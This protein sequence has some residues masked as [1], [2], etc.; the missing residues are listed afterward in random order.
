[1]YNAYIIGNGFSIN[2]VNLLI[3]REWIDK[4]AIDLRNLFSQGDVVPCA[5]NTVGFLSPNC[6]PTLWRIGARAYID[7]KESTQIISN[8]ICSYNVYQSIVQQNETVSIH[9]CQTSYF[10]LNKYL[11]NLFVYY[12]SLISDD[13]LKKIINDLPLLNRIK[14][15][16]V[17]ISYNYDI[18][19]ERLLSIKMNVPVNMH[20]AIKYV[21][22]I[23]IIKPHGSIDFKLNI[24]N[25]STHDLYYHQ[26]HNI[27]LSSNLKE[28]IL[29]KDTPALIIP[30]LGHIKGES[31]SWVEYIRSNVKTHLISSPQNVFF[32]GLSYD[33]VDRSEINEI[34]SYI[35]HSANITYINP[36]PAP[37]LDFIFSQHFKSYRHLCNERKLIYGNMESRQ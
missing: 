25:A 26:P 22:N 35:D 12:N 31:N 34:I 20:N 33:P 16:D 32:Y 4:N 37:E 9:D 15:N 17:V 3:E 5:D 23:A 6:C 29:K 36:S 30:P 2:V 27:T 14:E 18:L 28:E 8:I 7:S 10:E 13:M 11:R 24:D 19:I 1:M 21:G